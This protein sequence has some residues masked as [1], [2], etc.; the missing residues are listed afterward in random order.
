M[1]VTSDTQSRGPDMSPTVQRD[2][3]RN[4]AG[5]NKLCKNQ[6]KRGVLKYLR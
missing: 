6:V 2:V 3:R 4:F 5:T 1:T